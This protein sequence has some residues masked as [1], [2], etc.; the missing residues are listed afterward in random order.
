M[1]LKG[2]IL[3]FLL[4]WQSQITAYRI[5]NCC[6]PVCVCNDNTS[7]RTR[8]PPNPK[9]LACTHVYR[10][11]IRPISIA[12]IGHAPSMPTVHTGQFTVVY[13]RYIN[14]RCIFVHKQSIK[15][16]YK[17]HICWSKYIVSLWNRTLVAVI[18]KLSSTTVD[19]IR[20]EG[21]RKTCTLYG[22]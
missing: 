1:I 4:V 20:S 9:C 22:F 6:L 8:L 17:L 10:W 16:S 11:P 2:L 5:A 7:Y 18:D 15:H 3:E 13:C 12:C 14:T 19:F 21:E